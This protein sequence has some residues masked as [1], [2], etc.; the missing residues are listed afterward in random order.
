ML[1][2]R[3]FVVW[4]SPHMFETNAGDRCYDAVR[5]PPPLE[6]LGFLGCGGQ[7]MTWLAHD[8]R[9]NRKLVSKRFQMELTRGEDFY[10][11]LEATF[12]AQARVAAMTWV[13]PQVYS[14]EHFDH[15]VWL[16]LEFV[17]G[18]SLQRLRA[19]GNIT[20]GESHMLLI[21]VDLIN[22][23]KA[24]EAAGLVHGDLSPSNILIN[25]EGKTR[26]ID[27]SSSEFAGTLRSVLGVPGFVRDTE[28]TAKKLQF[29]DDQYAAG[30]VLYWLLA[31]ELPMTICD[32]TGQ[33]VVIRAK[34]PEQCSACGNLLWDIAA[35]LTSGAQSS[36]GMLEQLSESIRQ[37]LRLLPPEIRGVLGTYVTNAQC[38]VA[39]LEGVSRLPSPAEQAR[40]RSF[41]IDS[42]CLPTQKRRRMF[43]FSSCPHSFHHL[44]A[45]ILLVV[46][47]GLAGYLSFAQ[48]PLL[49]LDT[50]KVEA[51][52]KLP[53][54]FSHSWL[55]RQ[56]EQV[57]G[58]QVRL[59]VL[60]QPITAELDCD[61]YTCILSV[62]HK[63][64]GA[65][66]PHQQSFTASEQTE[67]W[68]AV[69]AN[70]G[71]AVAAR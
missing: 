17:E 38:A 64:D 5:L 39:G 54:G 69:I 45:P 1:C 31:A 65:S 23:L 36:I 49:V 27:F 15:T 59:T 44:L 28:P 12:A 43:D 56:I 29:S 6:N 2:D 33:M 20:I 32:P 42:H 19:E 14:V 41:V 26:F 70:L 18:I 25:S 21:A 34:K 60:P 52:T 51:N 4:G 30:C 61:H 11:R 8:P 50:V 7:G 58:K 53:R 22:S 71:R 47:S 40:D 63:V 10:L 48:V 57:L 3:D 37:Q 67:V 55:S 16:L 66:H 62:D 24:L 13:V 46:L 68:E 9:L 35:A